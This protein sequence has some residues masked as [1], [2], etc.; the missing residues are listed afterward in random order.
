MTW[1]PSNSCP[2]KKKIWGGGCI[3]GLNLAS[4]FLVSFHLT[5]AV[6]PLVKYRQILSSSSSNNLIIHGI[7]WDFQLCIMC[8]S[9]DLFQLRL[10]FAPL[11]TCVAYGVTLDNISWVFFSLLIFRNRELVVQIVYSTCAHDLLRKDWPHL[12]LL[13]L[14]SPPKLLI[15]YCKRCFRR[16]IFVAWGMCVEVTCRGWAEEVQSSF[17]KKLIEGIQSLLSL[18]VRWKIVLVDLN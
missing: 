3:L 14:V 6:W 17:K 11:W 18:S 5:V 7:S 13:F 9:I 12:V 10:R 2:P 16:Q 8:V 15:T 4:C 1:V